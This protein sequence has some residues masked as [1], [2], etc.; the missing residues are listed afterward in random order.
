MFGTIQGG[1][2]EVSNGQ[3]KANKKNNNITKYRGYNPDE[4]IK[5]DYYILLRSLFNDQGV[6]GP[7]PISTSDFRNG[8]VNSCFVIGH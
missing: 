6:V 3:I 5:K 2:W 7:F 8:F 1:F 4:Y